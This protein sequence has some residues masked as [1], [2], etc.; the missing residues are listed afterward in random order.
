MSCLIPL[1]RHLSLNLELGWWPESLIVSPPSPYHAGVTG[2]HDYTWIY[3]KVLG[4]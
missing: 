2:T 1:R 4:I 3:M